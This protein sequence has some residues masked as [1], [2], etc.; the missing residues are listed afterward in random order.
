MVRW[1]ME[2]LSI[3][4]RW[5]KIDSFGLLR[6]N[7]LIG[8]HLAQL[9]RCAL[10]RAGLAQHEIGIDRHVMLTDD[11]GIGDALEE[12][13]DGAAAQLF[14]R[15]ADAADRRR[16]EPPDVAVSEAD[17]VDV[18]GDLEPHRFCG[19]VDAE[20]DRIGRRQDEFGQ[21]V[22]LGELLEPL[23]AVLLAEPA[24]GDDPFL[25]DRD[26]VFLKRPPEA[27]EAVPADVDLGVAADEA[28]AAVADL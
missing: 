6:C 17:D 5:M 8:R 24:G 2:Y 10:D 25:P 16:E 12:H 14:G 20:S 15:L 13:F 26:A 22:P 7:I 4:M 19:A 1:W 11:V 27:V 28:E 3:L 18:V 9:A 23:D 21:L